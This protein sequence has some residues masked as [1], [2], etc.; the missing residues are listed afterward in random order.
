MQT[1]TN[2]K[3]CG[4]RADGSRGG[5]R[6]GKPNKLT[7]TIKEE[8]LASLE[9]VGGRKYLARQAIENPPAYL[10]LLGKVIP[11]QVHDAVGGLTI[12]VITLDT[13]SVPTP[14]VLCSPIPEH[15]APQRKQLAL[16]DE[17]QS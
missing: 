10:S 15:I 9:M 16:V 13:P 12:N 4:L 3:N 5:S 1:A 17:V 2:T 8:V 11:Q 14:G 6:L 7:R